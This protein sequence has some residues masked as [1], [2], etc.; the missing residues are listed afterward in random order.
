[1]SKGLE[2]LKDLK[3]AFTGHCRQLKCEENYIKVCENKF[4]KIEKELNALE[5]IKVLF[6]GRC[7]LYE[8]TTY[9]ETCNEQGC[10][11]KRIATTLY[12]LEFHNYDLHYEFH[13]HKEEYDL[14]KEV[15]LWD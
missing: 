15:L 4:S 3:N 14:L 6:Q 10:H 2:A 12:V 13:L 5:I 7:K 11:T 9:I 1:M 8:R